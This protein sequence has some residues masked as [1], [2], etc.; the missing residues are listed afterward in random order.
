MV[1]ALTAAG[2]PRLLVI[3]IDCADPRLI[4]GPLRK[5]MPNLDRLASRGVAGRLESCVPPTTIPA[6]VSMFTG[7]DPGELGVYGFRD[8]R[9]YSY[10]QGTLFSSRVTDAP[11]TWDK[12]SDAG[13]V[14]YLIGVPGSYPPWPIRGR[15]VSS[16]MTPDSDSCF[17]FP[18][19]LKDEVERISGGYILDVD[20]FRDLERTELLDQ[21]RTMTDRR[22]KL[23]CEWAAEPDWDFF[24]LVEIGNDRLN[25]GFLRYLDP[26][27][28]LH[29]PDH[30]LV[31]KTKN[32][33]GFLDHKIAA[34]V[35]AAGKQTAV[36]VVSDH[37]AQVMR[38]GFAINEWLLAQGDLV[39][40]ETPEKPQR[41]S[42]DMID[43]PRTRAWCA[44]GYSAKVY[45]N[46][47]GREPQGTVLPEDYETYRA[48]LATRLK[49]TR[50]HLGKPLGTRVFFPERIYRALRG[51]PPD[52]IVYFGELSWRALGKVGGG[53]VHLTEND[54][55]A[56]DANHAAQGIL[57]YCGPDGKV[58]LP[59][60]HSLTD[61]DG[62]ILSFFGIQNQSV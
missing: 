37:G 54:S 17:T 7:R 8:R 31:A 25:H 46:L 47:V 51:V 10:R 39:L 9:D 49:G 28:P 57:I 13:L 3:G 21:I 2:R 41:L 15:M 50:D 11:R 62:F 19:D 16:L 6:W 18:A 12:L 44:G 59:A 1:R 55:G 38:G 23:A 24:V 29:D 61:V 45:I 33:L 52:L 32:Y 35:E 4:F 53:R 48:D 20:N 30:P 5:S 58:S 60:V 14:S 56:D 34:L 27:H 42:I 40:L 36:L 43:W 22:F 26:S